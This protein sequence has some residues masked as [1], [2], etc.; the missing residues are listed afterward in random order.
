M[1]TPCNS[2]LSSFSLFAL[3]SL[4][5]R[6]EKSDSPPLH[7]RTRRSETKKVERTTPSEPANTTTNHWRSWPSTNSCRF[8][9]SRVETGSCLSKLPTPQPQEAYTTINRLR[10]LRSTNSCRCLR[11]RVLGDKFCEGRVVGGEEGRFYR[12]YPVFQ[13]ARHC[14]RRRHTQQSTNMNTKE[15]QHPSRGL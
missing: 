10:S 12:L 13:S 4:N 6:V 9:W 3:R 7:L 5:V 11:S 2:L 14:D 8:L 15:M 1:K